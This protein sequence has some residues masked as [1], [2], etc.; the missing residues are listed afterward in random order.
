MAIAAGLGVGANI[1]LAT[2]GSAAGMFAG[3]ILMG[4][5]WGVFAALGIFVAQKLMPSA[6]ATASAIFMSSTAV[7]SALGGLTGG[8]GAA[9]L[10][11]PVVFVIPAFFAVLAVIGL[12]FMAGTTPPGGVV[13]TRAVFAQHRCNAR[14]ILYEKG[15]HAVRGLSCGQPRKAARQA[16]LSQ[17][18]RSTT[19]VRDDNWNASDRFIIMSVP[20]RSGALGRRRTFTCG[21]RR[22]CV[23]PVPPVALR[24]AE[25]PANV[26]L[27][28][29]SCKP[30]RTPNGR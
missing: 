10:G 24:R 29:K 18:R 1:C 14:F 12:A 23:R 30:E 22:W 6:V 13:V 7:S 21:S 19:V 27:D 2:T 26:A 4:G 5:V 16:R 17:M 25:P 9:V 15:C 28:A 8:L 20:S 3:Q 11:L